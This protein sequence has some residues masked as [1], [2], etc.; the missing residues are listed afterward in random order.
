M[1]AAELKRNL[2]FSTKMVKRIDPFL[3]T[4]EMSQGKT[5]ILIKVDNKEDMYFYEWQADKFR[6]R[7]FMI[8]ELLEE[9]IDSGEIPHRDKNEDPFWDP[10]NPILVG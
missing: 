4:G 8:N 1:A 6:N 9:F 2:K 3:K 5:D 7:L 10:P